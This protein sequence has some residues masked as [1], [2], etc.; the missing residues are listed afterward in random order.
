MDVAFGRKGLG[1]SPRWV[2]VQG[3]GRTGT[4]PFTVDETPP[5]LLLKYDFYKARPIFI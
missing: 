4:H 3:R 5:V 2:L 1:L